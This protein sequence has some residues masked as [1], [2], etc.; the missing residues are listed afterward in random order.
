MNDLTLK[1][2]TGE[3]YGLLGANGA[4]KSTT[5]NLILG[6]LEADG[7]VIV[8]SLQSDGNGGISGGALV[9]DSVSDLL[10]R[11]DG[12]ALAALDAGGGVTVWR[13]RD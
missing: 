2:D 13:V 12:R 11:P 9:K 3:V 8:W 10:W 4:G 6:F 1:V 7:G 5:I